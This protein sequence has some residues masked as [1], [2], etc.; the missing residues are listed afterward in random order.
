LALISAG[1]WIN[2]TFEENGKVDNLVI[3]NAVVL[4][5]ALQLFAKIMTITWNF[6]EKFHMSVI[7]FA[8]I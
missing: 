5:G 8:N 3:N 6:D 4:F 1:T 7:I 2:V